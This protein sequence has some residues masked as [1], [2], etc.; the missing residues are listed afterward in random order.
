MSSITLY[1]G[2][3]SDWA[4]DTHVDMVFTHPYAP[5]PRALHRVPTVINL[6]LPMSERDWRLHCA[7]KWLGLTSTDVL[8]PVGSWARDGW[9]MVFSVHLPPRPVVL[10]DLGP[11]DIGWFP[12]ELV[13]RVLLSVRDVVPPNAVI[14]DGFMGRGT[15]GLVARELGYDYIGIDKNRE[16]VNIAADYLGVEASCV[17]SF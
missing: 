12:V 5:L 7:R 1:H 8:F 16:R 9:N 4:S 17:H 2:D 3:S 14:W 11:A 10:H 15:V 6:A 13:R